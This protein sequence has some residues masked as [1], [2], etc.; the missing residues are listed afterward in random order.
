VKQLQGNLFDCRATAGQLQGNLFDCR[1][2]YL[3]AG[4][5]QGN[6]FDYRATAGQPQGNLFDCR[7]TYLT[8][9]QDGMGLS[10][11]WSQSY[12]M[13]VNQVSKYYFN[14]IHPL[15]IEEIENKIRRLTGGRCQG[16]SSILH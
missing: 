11:E 16:S 12:L 9:H 10:R 15:R 7:A 13:N 1:A 3:T 2:T 6:L 4:Q 14:N 5:L 8:V